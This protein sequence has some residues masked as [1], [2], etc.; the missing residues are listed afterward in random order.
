M[1]GNNVVMYYSHCP[2]LHADT[3]T[4]KNVYYNIHINCVSDTKK[5]RFYNNPFGSY[6]FS[7]NNL[8]QYK[9]TY[10]CFSYISFVE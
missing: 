9:V 5:Q 1:E 2:H 8:L 6:S 7:R 4:E 3:H 10:N